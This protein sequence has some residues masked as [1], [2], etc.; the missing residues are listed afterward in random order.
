M[1]SS[2]FILFLAGSLLFGGKTYAE[3]PFGHIYADLSP[4][5][6]KNNDFTGSGY[7]DS[8]VVTPEAPEDTPPS[9]STKAT[10]YD[11]TVN[12]LHVITEEEAPHLLFDESFVDKDYN[13]NIIGYDSVDAEGKVI[14]SALDGA[15]LYG[16]FA[17]LYKKGS[18]H[19]STISLQGIKNFQ[20]F[21][22]T[23]RF[24]AGGAISLFNGGY[25]DFTSG[26]IDNKVTFSNNVLQSAEGTTD[27]GAIF[28]T[29]GG[30][31]SDIYA[32]F[33]GN[34]VLT[35][36]SED[37]NGP[38]YARGGA[39]YVG[40]YDSGSPEY[41]PDSTKDS[42]IGNI[43]GDFKN[44]EAGYGGAIY[45]NSR[46]HIG[47][48]TGSFEN[49]L[50]EGGIQPG[51]ST[52]GCNG[53]A[54]RSYHGNIGTINATFTNNAAHSTDSSATGG[55]ISL[56]STKVN[57]GFYGNF[58]GN[59]A[60]SDNS[61]AYGGAVVVKD[62]SGG[63]NELVFNN[64]DFIGN[65][66]GTALEGEGSGH[67][68]RGGAFYIKDSSDVVLSATGS[69]ELLISGNY[70]VTGASWDKETNTITEDAESVRD[71][72]AI[73]LDTTDGKASKLSMKVA[74][75]ATLKMD[76]G[77]I[78][79]GVNNQLVIQENSSERFGVQ[80]N[81]DIGV[82]HLVIESGGVLLGENVTRVDG[83]VTT[84]RFINDANVDVR[85]GAELKGNA[86][87]LDN[88]GEVKLEGSGTGATAGT[89]ELTGGTLSAHIN[90]TGTAATKSGHIHITGKTTIELDQT[91]HPDRTV[92]NI[93]ADTISIYDTLSIEKS[94]SVDVE[95]LFFYGY[96]MHD[97][98]NGG[99]QIIA[100]T[101]SILNFTSM[102]LYFGEA[103]IGDHFD[104]IV[105]D[106]DILMPAYDLNSFEAE[107]FSVSGRLLE[108][109]IDYRVY[110]NETGGVSVELL[111]HVTIPEPA[112]ATLSLLALTALLA[113]RRRKQQA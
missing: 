69:E 18:E 80:L 72:N 16:G 38:Q 46:G 54:I 11:T 100:H 19:N 68:V 93:N 3:N 27:G 9:S 95:T 53:G 36:E 56:E 5:I 49:N 109:D 10:D 59:V 87:S 15:G 74:D 79:T 89:L 41:V 103:N 35:S 51:G 42:K 45:I 8:F 110:N 73:Y 4:D 65:V 106:N 50:A 2:P 17:L 90:Q 85:A 14:E 32:D 107:V 34:K 55:A 6:P 33:I 37:F 60:F 29:G 99:N 75:N 7:D 26:G 70:T 112:T 67:V 86:D 81:G 24:S 78:G 102:E 21:S 58:E 76:D 25:L 44:N 23:N 71:Y 83:S 111:V 40:N 105:Y 47:N 98:N 63:E 97:V 88:V 77:I 64:T 61:A 39:I 48:I 84:G 12:G 104:L 31:V 20:N 91:I 92:T 113:R 62:Q 82:Q 13:V 28:I 22:R 52:G 57:G 108:R 30:E 43:Y 94:T 1:K 66:A 96:D 101:E